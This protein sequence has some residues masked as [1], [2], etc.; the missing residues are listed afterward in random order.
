MQYPLED[1]SAVTQ[2][3]LECLRVLGAQPTPDTPEYIAADFQLLQNFIPKLLTS[4]TDLYAWPC[5]VYRAAIGHD[6]YDIRYGIRTVMNNLSSYTVTDRPYFVF[7]LF[8]TL[9][10]DAN[11]E[12]RELYSCNSLNES[13]AMQL[14][15]GTNSVKAHYVPTNETIAESPAYALGRA[16]DATAEHSTKSKV[17]RLP[18]KILVDRPSEGKT[19][20]SDVLMLVAIDVQDI[21][22]AELQ[23]KLYDMVF[24]EVL[25]LWYWAAL[26]KSSPRMFDVRVTVNELVSTFEGLELAPYWQAK[27]DVYSRVARALSQSQNDFFN[28][29]TMVVRLSLMYFKPRHTESSQ[30]KGAQQDVVPGI[31]MECYQRGSSKQLGAHLITEKHPIYVGEDWSECLDHLMDSLYESDVSKIEVVSYFEGAPELMEKYNFDES[32]FH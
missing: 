22:Q 27:R 1:T 19:R 25:T 20:T 11:H 29:T 30:T 13:I 4:S 8:C 15:I 9:E 17:H 7:G 16:Y 24:E 26:P 23:A 28:L 6:D 2:E 10:Y 12:I 32:P 3:T 21:D 31:T 18:S 14:G 5:K